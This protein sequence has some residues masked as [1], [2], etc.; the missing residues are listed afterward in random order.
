MKPL[1]RYGKIYEDAKPVLSKIKNMGYNLA[2]LTNTPWGCP[3]SIWKRELEKHDIAQFID[4][5]VCCYDAG[6]RKPDPRVF[7]HLLEKMGEAPENCIFIGDDPRWDVEGPRAVGM[8][9]LLLDR[10][11]TKENSIQNLN[12]VINYLRKNN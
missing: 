8:K 12:E 5:T 4:T 3:S 9:T 2:V 1:S 10:S 11:G 7:H 6:W